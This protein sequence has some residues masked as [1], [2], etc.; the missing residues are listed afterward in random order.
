MI[1]FNQYLIEAASKAKKG[2][3]HAVDV[4]NFLVSGIK[5][6]DTTFVAK[7]DLFD[8]SGHGQIETPS[9]AGSLYKPQTRYGVKIGKPTA[10]GADATVYTHVWNGKKWSTTEHPVEIAQGNKIF[11]RYYESEQPTTREVPQRELRKKLL[12]DPNAPVHGESVS[13]PTAKNISFKGLIKNF[14]DLR[15]L[16][17]YQ[18]VK[19]PTLSFDAAE[20]NRESKTPSDKRTGTAILLN[21]Q[22][23]NLR[24]L[25][26]NK[27]KDDQPVYSRKIERAAV[28]KEKIKKTTGK[29]VKGRT[30]SQD[31]QLSI[32]SVEDMMNA[33]D[34]QTAKGIDS[35]LSGLE[36]EHSRI[37]G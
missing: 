6:R 17:K 1:S 30:P 19:E 32:T 34:E 28:D 18:E 9:E 5:N 2:M 8:E 10:N 16:A 4:A 37:H 31:T 21:L 15:Q 24:G 33:H 36:R 14:G 25:S 35:I 29:I 26:Y 3:Q 11:S 7:S 12:S 13:K 22:N 23:E 27:V 20:T